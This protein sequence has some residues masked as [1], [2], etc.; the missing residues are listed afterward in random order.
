MVKWSQERGQ[1][2]SDSK[3]R[4]PKGITKTLS[5]RP[6]K[7]NRG[8]LLE[9]DLGGEFIGGRLVPGPGSTGPGRAMP[10]KTA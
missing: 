6:D 9:P 10:E 7:G 5:P 3:T 8:P 2:K 1:T 4:I